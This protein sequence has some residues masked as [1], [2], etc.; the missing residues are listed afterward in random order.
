VYY[1]ERSR[2]AFYTLRTSGSDPTLGSVLQTS[3]SE[4]EILEQL[5]SFG[6]VYPA[7]IVTGMTYGSYSI[8]ILWSRRENWQR[9][10]DFEMAA[11]AEMA[12]RA[13]ASR[14][15]Y[16]AQPQRSSFSAG[17]S[18]GRF[19]AEGGTWRS[20]DGSWSQAGEATGASVDSA[21]FDAGA[22]SALHYIEWS[23]GSPG[24][25]RLLSVEVGGKRVAI[26]PIAVAG[27]DFD[28]G[29]Q[30]WNSRRQQMLDDLSAWTE[31]A[32]A[33][34]RA[35]IKASFAGIRP[36]TA[37]TD[38]GAAAAWRQALE[39]VDRDG[40]ILRVA[41]AE[42][43][44]LLKRD[45]R[46]REWCRSAFDTAIGAVDDGTRAA[47]E[48][49]WTSEIARQGREQSR[50]EK[51]AAAAAA[52]AAAAEARKREYDF[53][54]GGWFRIM[55]DADLGLRAGDQER[56]GSRRIYIGS[57]QWW[58]IESQG[59][60]VSEYDLPIDLAWPT[61]AGGRSH[62]ENAIV[63]LCGDDRPGEACSDILSGALVYVCSHKHRQWNQRWTFDAVVDGGWRISLA[64]QPGIALTWYGDRGLCVKPWTGAPN[65]IWRLE[66]HTPPR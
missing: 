63:Q 50:L 41:S 33:K 58:R 12:R 54:N 61:G 48:A 37:L 35:E 64:G 10:T 53:G 32:V 15:A 3:V 60:I 55:R 47:M 30:A 8:R 56:V 14:Q 36:A 62:D 5:T 28:A 6:Y 24:D 52:A 39:S 40:M 20:A 46:M 4:A 45:P 44:H 21:G 23:H 66:R 9:M 2:D 34:I 57:P 16:S 18:F 38:A 27:D 25:P 29:I 19:G 22:S 26:H 13:N 1:V 11:K 42:V 51:E 59:V 49:E 65:Q 31:T 43:T 17:A 7:G